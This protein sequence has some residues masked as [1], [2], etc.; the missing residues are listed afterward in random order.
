M[1]L[2]ARIAFL[3]QR[4]H[5]AFLHCLFQPA[6]ACCFFACSE[7]FLFLAVACHDLLRRQ[8]DLLANWAAKPLNP[9][10]PPQAEGRGRAALRRAEHLTLSLNAVE[11][12]REAPRSG[13]RGSGVSPA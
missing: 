8:F 10:A 13:R 9:A 1:L 5:A 2:V 4:V 7:L 11:H 12:E 3:G 6:L